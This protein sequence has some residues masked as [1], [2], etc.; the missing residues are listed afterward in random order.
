MSISIT[1]PSPLFRY[2]ASLALKTSAANGSAGAKPDDPSFGTF[3]YSPAA[4]P[5][6]FAAPSAPANP[7]GAKKAKP[8]LNSNP[9]GGKGAAKPPLG[10]GGA[11]GGK[12]G[13]K[14]GGAIS[15]REI[16]SLDVNGPLMRVRVPMPS[17]SPLASPPPLPTYLTLNLAFL[18][19][20][21][22]ARALSN[23]ACRISARLSTG[24]GADAADSVCGALRSH[25][26]RLARTARRDV[27]GARHTP[28]R[29]E[30]HRVTTLYV[31]T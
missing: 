20:L 28:R 21:D 31:T 7:F 19:P 23:S 27:C 8:G 4:A 15:G 11:A 26:L 3:C 1:S 2:A 18:L 10:G 17:S 30:T 24:E 16:E 29:R 5:S 25:R 22:L 6:A 13:G 12:A 9:F 14:P